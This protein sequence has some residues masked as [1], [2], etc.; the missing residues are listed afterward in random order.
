MCELVPAEAVLP[1]VTDFDQQYYHLSVQDNG[2]GFEPAYA[3][4]IFEVFQRLHGRSEYG[5]TGIGLALCKKIMENH[6]GVIRAEAQLQQGA[7]FH[8]YLPVI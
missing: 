7:T 2:I 1:P 8:L 5:G 6:N 4:K 3:H